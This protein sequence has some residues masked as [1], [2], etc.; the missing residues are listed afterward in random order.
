MHSNGGTRKKDIE[1]SKR[2][3]QKHKV[4][5]WVQREIVGWAVSKEE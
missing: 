5:Q 2:E 1:E 4:P 3:E